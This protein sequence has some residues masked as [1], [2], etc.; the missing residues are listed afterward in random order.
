ML[1]T[2]PLRLR[3]L[4]AAKRQERARSEQLRSQVIAHA[5]ACGFGSEKAAGALN[6][7]LKSLTDSADECAE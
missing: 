2:P 5:V 1:A 3:L 7:L 4:E 6:E